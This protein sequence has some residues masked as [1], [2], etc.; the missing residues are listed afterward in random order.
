MIIYTNE[1]NPLA[2]QSY[3]LG[4]FAGRTVQ[5]ETI[6]LTGEKTKQRKKI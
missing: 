2:L 5:M 6:T 4:K 1:G 3:L